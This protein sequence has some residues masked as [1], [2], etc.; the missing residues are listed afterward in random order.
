[1]ILTKITSSMEKC[2]LDS[3]IADYPELT[4]LS[5]LKNERVSFQFLYTDNTTDPSLPYRANNHRLQIDGIAKELYS[6]RHVDSVPITIPS[7]T[8]NGDGNFLRTTPG[9]YPDVLSPIYQNIVS[10]MRGQLQAIWVEIDL[11]ERLPT[12]EHSITLQIV[13]G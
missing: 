11:C 10:I 2:F 5:A 7:L 12:G 9:L 3:N 13:D 8:E 1:M 6:I 4:H